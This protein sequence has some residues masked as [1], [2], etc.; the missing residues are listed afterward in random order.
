MANVMRDIPRYVKLIER[1]VIDATTVITKRHTLAESRQAVQDTA[2]LHRRLDSVAL[3]VGRLLNVGDLFGRC[4]A[5]D[6][7]LNTYKDVVVTVSA[8]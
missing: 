2:R 7:A 8:A 6:G 3:A 4:P 1:G 5:S